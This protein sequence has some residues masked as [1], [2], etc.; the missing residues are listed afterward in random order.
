MIKLRNERGRLIS[1]EEP[2]AKQLLAT[3]HYTQAKEG[4]PIYDPAADKSVPKAP[5]KASTPEPVTTPK[6]APKRV[7]KPAAKKTTSQAQKPTL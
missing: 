1:V 4:E 5:L 6:P 7:R 2:R 3:G